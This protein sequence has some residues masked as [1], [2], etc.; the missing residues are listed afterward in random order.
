MKKLTVTLIGIFLSLSVFAKS[1]VEENDVTA[2]EKTQ[3][4][5]SKNIQESMTNQIYDA[6][7]QDIEDNTPVTASIVFYPKLNKITVT[8]SVSDW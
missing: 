5:R 2:L 4:E 3:Q 1:E 8:A 7:N 6:I